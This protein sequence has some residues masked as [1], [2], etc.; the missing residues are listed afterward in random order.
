LALLRKASDDGSS[1]VFGTSM[2]SGCARRNST[3]REDNEQNLSCRP[4]FRLK[5]E[6]L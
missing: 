1:I 3:G 6:R 5:Q 4:E 2:N